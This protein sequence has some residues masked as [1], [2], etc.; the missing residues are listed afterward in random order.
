MLEEALLKIENLAQRSHTDTKGML[1]T[2]DHDLPSGFAA[3]VGPLLE[4]IRAQTAIL[5]DLLDIQ[6]QH[7]SAHRAVKAILTGELVRLDD[8]YGRKLGGY[9]AVDEQVHT[10]LD[11]ILDEI[12]SSLVAMLDSLG[13]TTQRRGVR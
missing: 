7:R 1:T 8:S 5:R 4:S 2:Y 10:T 6:Q 11:P 9:G 13:G 12:R 3:S